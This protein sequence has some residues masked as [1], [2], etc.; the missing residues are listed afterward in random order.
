MQ[1][2]SKPDRGDPAA[3]PGSEA[4][5]MMRSYLKRL[6]AADDKMSGGAGRSSDV[7]TDHAP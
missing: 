5:L 3:I 4:T 6:G 1:R 2:L 7:P